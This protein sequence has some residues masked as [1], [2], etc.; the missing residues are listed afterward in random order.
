MNVQIIKGLDG[1]DEYVLLP[2]S[3]YYVLRD[4]I[5]EE[6]SGLDIMSYQQ[7]AYEPFDPADFVQNPI[8]LA[9]M[10]AG[11]KQVE[12]ARRMNVSQAYIS[13]LEH[14]DTV[15]EQIMKRIQGVLQ[16]KT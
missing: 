11:I 7:D 10:K 12:L 9:R 4:Q 15:S 5:E 13:K 8:A 16:T 1:R 14:S 2:V 6:L 3:I